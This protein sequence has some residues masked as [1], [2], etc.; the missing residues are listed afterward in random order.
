MGFF[1]DDDDDFWAMVDDIEMDAEDE[2]RKNCKKHCPDYKSCKANFK[3]CKH[4][5]KKKSSWF[6]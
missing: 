6:F 2:M 5:K 3:K 4:K 1:D